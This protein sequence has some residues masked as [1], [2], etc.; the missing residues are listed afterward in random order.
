MYKSGVCVVAASL[1]VACGGG[2]GGGGDGS[3]VSGS[4]SVPVAVSTTPLTLTESNY[5]GVAQ[6]A[7]DGTNNLNSL[8]SGSA[9]L[10]SGVQA[11]AQPAWMPAL[12]AQL[13]T[14]NTLK[15]SNASMLVGVETVETEACARSGSV[16]VTLNDLNGNR[17]AD[18]GDSVVMSFN[19]CEIA[20]G[21]V[22]GSLSAQIHNAVRGR[23]NSTS[24]VDASIVLSNFKVVSGGSSAFA[25]G[26]LRLK[27]VDASSVETL[28]LTSSSL[29][30][31]TTVQG[32]TK[33]FGLSGFKATLTN[34]W[35]G[36]SQT[37]AGNLSMSAYEN[38]RVSIETTDMWLFQNG[39]EY[40]YR[41]QMVL[42]GQAGSKVRLT[43]QLFTAASAPTVLLELDANGDGTYEKSE[44][45]TWDSLQ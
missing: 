11:D 20:E 43:A 23:A 21:V 25:S 45:R 29:T 39:A 16:T 26:D 1:L 12:V 28:D 30:S 34:G 27:W 2:G 6:T 37:Y 42:T 24:Q 35:S 4:G 32:V 40:P 14:I 41:G 38:K 22:S 33:G 18:A 9:S 36:D 15:V 13:K 17:E 19:N 7:V 44:T 3:G 31:S 10:L 8:S 5:V